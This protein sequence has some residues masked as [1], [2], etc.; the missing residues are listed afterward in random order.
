MGSRVLVLAAGTGVGNNV[1]RSLR[2]G[3]PDLLL[4]GAHHD[5]FALKKSAADRHYLVHESTHASFV[6]S[7]RRV[8]ERER[9]DLLV[10]TSDRDVRACSDQRDAIPCRLFLPSPRAIA[11]CQDKY[12]LA[13]HLRAHGVGAPTTQAIGDLAS[14]ESVF[15]RFAPADLVWCRVRTGN[16]STGAIPVKSAAQARAWIAYW[17]E[18]RGV[19]STAFTLCEY[20]PGRDFGCQ[21]LWRDGRPVLTKTFERLSYFIGG[22]SS[23]SGVSSVAALA[24]TV[25]E[26]RVERVALAAIDA[27]DERA[28]GLFGVDL[29]EN[30]AEEPCVTEINVGRPLAGTNLLD[31]TGKHNMMLTYV[32]LALGEP[33][34]LQDERDV[35][36]DGY[37]VRDFDTL[38]GIIHAEELF[39]GIHDARLGEEDHA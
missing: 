24:K 18:M 15:D 32:R 35:A 3:D 28:T 31:L 19:P 17:A 25:D 4:I 21:S 5:R 8:I 12:D 16:G 34:E 14:V 20:L 13:V 9:I 6:E 23:P 27:A 30:T 37:A 22:G 11:L 2:V 7:L 10:P 33:V 26:P 36:A 39:D 38:P 29:K 1:L